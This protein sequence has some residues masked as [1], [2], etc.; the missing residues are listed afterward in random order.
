M[1]KPKV[2]E[3]VKQSNTTEI[4]EFL[5]RSHLRDKEKDYELPNLLV[6]LLTMYLLHLH[7]ANILNVI[8]KAFDRVTYTNVF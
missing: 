7:T 2:K 1:E 4:L 5:K 3:R 8:S 6:T